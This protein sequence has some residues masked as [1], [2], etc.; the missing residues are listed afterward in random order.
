[1]IQKNKTQHSRPE[2]AVPITYPDLP[3]SQH[4]S[5]IQKSLETNQ[6][7]I[8]IG[9]T[10]S[11]KTTQLP[12]LCL[13]QGRGRSGV[14]IHT[15]PRR[16]A[17]KGIAKRLQDELQQPSA[18]GLKIR[19]DDKTSPDNYVQVMTDGLL[20]NLLARDPLLRDCDTLI[21]DEAHERSL[22][23]DFLLGLIKKLLAKRP[24]FRLIIT[25]ATIK[26]HLFSEF[27]KSAP[28]F[29]VSGRTYPVAIQYLSQDYWGYHHPDPKTSAVV[30]AV[31]RIYNLH[32]QFKLPE[33]EEGYTSPQNLIGN[34]THTLDTLV[35][36]PGERQIH[37]AAQALKRAFQDKF[38]ILPLYARLAG[39]DQSKVFNP[40]HKI[41]IVL[42]TNLAETSITVP[43]IGF[44][45]D[46]G[47][48]RT[49]RYSQ[50]RKVQLLPIESISKASAAQ[51]AGRCGRIASGAC[52]RLYDEDDFETRQEYPEAE[53]HR[54]HLAGVILQMKAMRLGE[55]DSFPFIEPPAQRLINDGYQ[56]LEELSAVQDKRVT[57]LGKKM[58]RLPVDPRIARMIMSAGD[59]LYEVL[60]IASALSVMD[61]IESHRE[62]RD[63]VRQFHSQFH[64]KNSDFISKV[65]LWHRLEWHRQHLTR[66]EFQAFCDKH[67]ISIARFYE[68]RDVH[69]QLLTLMRQGAPKDEAFELKPKTQWAQYLVSVLK[70]KNADK[71]YTDWQEQL[72][73]GSNQLIHTPIIAAFATQIAMQDSETGGYISCRQRH[74]FVHPSSF[75]KVK[76]PNTNPKANE[77]NKSKKPQ[78]V[79]QE[80]LV[81]GEFLETQKLWARQVAKVDIQWILPQVSHMVNFTYAEPHWSKKMGAVVAQRTTHLLGLTL[82]KNT[83]QLYSHIDAQ[84]CR[85]IFI[86]TAF[87]EQE[88]G[89]SRFDR[90]LT[91]F[92]RVNQGLIE[93]VEALEAKARTSSLMASDEEIFAFFD[94]QIPDT[95]IDRRSFFAWWKKEKKQNPELLT[96][97]RDWFLKRDDAFDQFPKTIKINGETFQLE[98]R[99]EPGHEDDGVTLV[100]SDAHLF[101]LNPAVLDWLVPGLITEKCEA[102]IRGLP[103]A[104]RKKFVPVP[105]FVSGFLAAEYSATEPLT[106]CLEDFARKVTGTQMRQL[107]WPEVGGHLKM[108]LKVVASQN[109]KKVLAKG[110]DL[111]LLR[112]QQRD[113][114][115]QVVASKPAPTIASKVKKVQDSRPVVI[116]RIT[117]LPEMLKPAGTTPETFSTLAEKDGQV[118]LIQTPDAVQAE[119]LLYQGLQALLVSQTNALVK[120]LRKPFMQ[121]PNVRKM[122]AAMKAE[123]SFDNDGQK[124][125]YFWQG[126]LKAAFEKTFMQQSLPKNA[127]EAKTFF[128]ARTHLYGAVEKALQDM[129]KIADSH[130]D[131]KYRISF[132]QKKNAI[133]LSPVEQDLLCHYDSLFS[134]EW[135]HTP[136]EHRLSSWLPLV[137]GLASRLE[138]MGQR[139]SKDDVEA[140]QMMSYHERT[141]QIRKGISSKPLELKRRLAHLTWG[142]Q[143]V[144]SGVFA[145]H[146]KVNPKLSLKNFISE[147]G[148]LETD[149]RKS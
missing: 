82:S 60:I 14:I 134:L 103:K 109:P 2:F 79:K 32:S 130:V 89:D 19:F 30:E 88:L 122:V 55:P 76:K 3:I 46:S 110:A 4:I 50:R 29:S 131:I 128:E 66:K 123:K 10:G 26:H 102:L 96:F 31:A 56:L 84:V 5:E 99:F 54:T 125:D 116:S 124:Q 108:K 141:E 77:N 28:V 33:V 92:M 126:I 64:S 70:D 78:K 58:S 101:K 93:E 149:M 69:K 132:L 44:V 117:E 34:R 105:Q 62:A 148:T 139:G 73:D 86:Q 17:A 113:G 91:L 81:I 104:D 11:G 45:V 74:C 119:D 90:S 72:T 47:L 59:A 133:N 143:A 49:S 111:D 40:G 20:L 42:A 43:R 100:V 147:L 36:L 114:A 120:S 106:L 144:R 16:L 57:K 138:K 137:Q 121:Q 24:E 80:W 65:I 52:I 97:N 94:Q 118:V 13:E 75:V 7:V 145:Q 67:F 87:V 115:L 18:V 27:F 107:N 98:Y 1:M 23:I 63:Q 142:L 129:T 85:E 37:D 8:V 71:P 95:I 39:A 61:V 68:W 140:R 112:A 135:L 127:Q 136:S 15:Q 146:I 21:I 35:F 9:E 6:V 22:N 25:S 41:R 48:V 51:R 83:N 12:K 53:I 38:D